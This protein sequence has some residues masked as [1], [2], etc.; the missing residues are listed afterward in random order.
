[1][2]LRLTILAVLVFVFFSYAPTASALSCGTGG[3][4]RSFCNS[5]EIQASSGSVANFTCGAQICCLPKPATASAPAGSS[6]SDV[7]TSNPVDNVLGAP[8]TNNNTVGNI[9][10]TTFGT[11]AVAPTSINGTPITG[12]TQTPAGTSGGQSGGTT[13][14]SGGQSGNTARTGENVQLI[15]PLQGGG[16]LESFLNSILAVVIR[17]GT[18]V[19]I[20]MM[21]YV[22]YLFVA[23]RGEPGEITK[24]R[25]ALLWTVVGA[26][27]LLGAQVIAIGIRATVQALSVGG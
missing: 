16:N 20:L 5:N 12:R 1:M 22:G 15:N 11:G 8:A 7:Q 18:V 14:V 26:L 24:A 19:V 4:C 23:A 21:V 3:T 9:N 6:F 27:I 25:Q 13:G 2:K 17:I 10:T